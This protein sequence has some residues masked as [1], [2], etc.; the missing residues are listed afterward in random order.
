MEKAKNIFTL[1]ELLVVIAIIAILASMLLPALNKAREKAKSISCLNNLKQIGLGESNYAGDFAGHYVIGGDPSK[2]LTIGSSG[3]GAYVW[4]NILMRLKYF[5]K[6]TKADEDIPHF[7]QLHCPSDNVARNT[8]GGLKYSKRSYRAI[9]GRG[10]Y[11]DMYTPGR[12]TEGI[13]SGAWSAK[14][15]SIKDPSGT[16]SMGEF[17]DPNNLALFIGHIRRYQS[18]I[19]DP[20]PFVESFPH[21]TSGNVLFGDGH[22]ASLKK[23]MIT[24]NMYTSIKD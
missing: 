15:A 20:M 2:S 18:G 9:A 17:H 6:A 7:A 1:I 23:E 21:G 14:Y 16:L 11:T 22:A 10:T 12:K 4:D 24:V 3:Y 13:R 19:V 5:S 8:S